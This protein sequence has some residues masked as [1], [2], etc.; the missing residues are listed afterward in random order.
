VFLTA[1]LL[2]VAA[3][4]LCAGGIVKTFRVLKLDPMHVLMWIGLAEEPV[5]RV[6]PRR[7]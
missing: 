6:A 1:G 4:C 3:I 5:P 2:T 7:R